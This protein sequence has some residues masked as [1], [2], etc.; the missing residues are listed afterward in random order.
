VI[1]DL[2]RRVTALPKGVIVAGPQGCRA[3][4][5][6]SLARLAAV[7]GYPL[8]TDV[9][10]N[11]R[12][13][14][15]DLSAVLAGWDAYLRCPEWPARHRPQIVLRFGA[16]LTWKYGARYLDDGGVFQVVV[17]PEATWDDPTRRA[18]WRIVADPLLVANALADALVPGGSGEAEGPGAPGDAEWRRAWGAAEAAV[19]DSAAHTVAEVKGT[20][21]WVYPAALAAMPAGGMVCAA[22][23]MAVRDLDSFSR[24]MDKDLT[25]VVN[26]GAAGIDGTLSTALGASLASGAPTVLFTGDLAFLHDINGLTVARTLGLSLAVVLVNDRGG[27]IFAYLDIADHPEYEALF[28]ADPQV[29]VADLCRGYGVGHEVV[30]D[31]PG[32]GAA[33]DAAFAAGGVHV[34]EVAVDPAANTAAPRAHWDR[35]ARAVAR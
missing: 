15:H 11:V 14:T 29:A 30:G 18:A 21:P 17:D 20:S 13:G 6:T 35:V 12:F 22:N 28:R 8:L 24:P 32:L 9:A 23:S 25:V 7:T 5:G 4:L 33:L 2:A 19:R 26:R 1:Q 27:G 10:S 16:S 3:G 31:A 34:L